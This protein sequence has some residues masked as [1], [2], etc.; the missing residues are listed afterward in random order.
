MSLATSNS[1]AVSLPNH[2]TWARIAAVPAIAACMLLWTGPAAGWTAFAIFTLA[3][4]SDYFDGWLARLWNQQSELGRMLDPIADKL[5]VGI[6]LLLLV[7]E[8]GIGGWSLWAAIIILAREILVSGLREFL[9]GLDVKVLV[10]WLAKWKTALQL[11]ALGALLAA[12]VAEVHLPG[13]TDMGVGLL[14]ASALLTGY[15]GYAYLRAALGHAGGQAPRP[16]V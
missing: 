8:G 13:L 3:A 2:I 5:L 7:A 10:T 12:R 15:T 6:V 1:H 14:W 9:A 16:R 11:V 4:I